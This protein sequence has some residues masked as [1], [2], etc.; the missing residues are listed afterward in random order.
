MTLLVSMVPNFVFQQ[1][2]NWK[3]QVKTGLIWIGFDS[4]F[5]LIF[6]RYFEQWRR[7]YLY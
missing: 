4:G 3:V 6:S 5:L 2:N 1:N 7:Q